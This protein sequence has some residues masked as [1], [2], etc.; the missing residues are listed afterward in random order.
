ML[1]SD[2][3]ILFKLATPTDLPSVQNL[4]TENKLPIGG[5]EDQFETFIVAFTD[6][7]KLIGC[8]G[9]E[10]YD[11]YGLIRSVVVQS[12][13]QHKFLGSKLVEQVEQLAKKHTISQIY[14]LTETAKD[15]FAKKGY[16]V[17][18]RNDVPKHIQESYEYSTACKVSAVVMK[19]DLT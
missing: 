3:S 5:I 2:D 16:T 10:K 6:D 1:R 19:K 11:N 13:F 7:S 18:S 14:L 9:L 12:A 17:I 8:A 15:F 4:L